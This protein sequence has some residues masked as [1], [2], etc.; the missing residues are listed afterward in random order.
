MQHRS[1]LL[2]AVLTLAACGRADRAVVAPDPA[3]SPA[4][5]A[6][7]EDGDAEG[8]FAQ[9]PCPA[10]HKDD[11][12]RACLQD[13]VG[14]CCNVASIKYEYEMLESRNNGDMAQSQAYRDQMLEILSHGCD[15]EDAPS[16]EE[17]ETQVAGSN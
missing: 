12:E 15:L 14:A 9:S 13:D 1:A 7:D 10:P 2:L 5:E 17:L 11:P 3:P 8:L 6:V 16:C 4:V